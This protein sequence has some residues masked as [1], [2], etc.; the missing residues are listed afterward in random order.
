MTMSFTLGVLRL[1]L[2]PLHSAI[3]N[4]KSAFVTAN[5]LGATPGEI[6]LFSH[7]HAAFFILIDWD[8]R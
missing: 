8:K 4:L 3:R 7:N 1:A 5:F 2:L 6:S